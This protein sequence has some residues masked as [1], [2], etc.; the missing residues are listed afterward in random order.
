VA[1]SGFVSAREHRGH[2]LPIPGQ[3]GI[4][5][6]VYAVMHT[7]EPPPL[8]LPIDRV[9]AP[10]ERLELSAANYPVLPPRQLQNR[11]VRGVFS[12][13]SAHIADKRDSTRV[14]PR[15]VARVGP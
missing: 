1:Q 8:H 5:D 9:I 12:R 13:F 3:S 14:R 4:T 7:V 15:K 10:P 6:H 2:E 11:S